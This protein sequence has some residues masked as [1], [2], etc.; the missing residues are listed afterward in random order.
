MEH[1]ERQGAEQY[2]GTTVIEPTLENDDATAS[3]RQSSDPLTN[4]LGQ[5]RNYLAVLRMMEGREWQHAVP[6]L[7]ALQAQHPTV[8]ELTELLDEATF[9]ASMESQWVDQVTVRQGFRLPVKLLTPAIA[10]LSLGFLLISSVFYYGYNQ[11]VNALV[12]QQTAL[13]QQAQATLAA[14]QPREALDLFTQLLAINPTDVAARRGQREALQQLRV[15]SDYQIA[16]DHIGVGNYQQALQ[17]LTNLQTTTPRYRDVDKRIQELQKLLVAPRFFADAELAFTNGLWVTA[18]A[19]YE[20]LRRLDGTYE[21]AMTEEHLATAYFKVG[22]QIVAHRPADS[23]APEQALAYFQKAR[24][25]QPTDAVLKTEIQLLHTYLEGERLANQASYESAS[26]VLLP[27]FKSRPT[28]F[29]GYVSEL[30]YR[31]Y[32]AIGER[33]VSEQAL[34]DALGVYQQAATLGLDQSNLLE[35]RITALSFLLTP[36]PTAMSTEP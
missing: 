35:Q 25:L 14:D 9:R 8:C 1:N 10:F 31:A 30:L 17:L 13:L 22:Q 11:R 36:T 20:Q 24:Q 18:I 5:E 26:Q 19:N 4:Q 32:V 15:A 16:L 2:F 33:Y 7:R 28:Y 21:A 29:G 23:T 6:M 34:A 27:I 12:D 3:T